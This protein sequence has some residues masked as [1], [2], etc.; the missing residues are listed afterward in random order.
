M[1]RGS[2]DLLGDPSPPPPSALD[3]LPHG[4]ILVACAVAATA[5]FAAFP[6]YLEPL[7]ETLLGLAAR[8][9]QDQAR[10]PSLAVAAGDALSRIASPRARAAPLSRGGRPALAC[11]RAYGSQ[12]KWAGDREEL[13]VTTCARLAPPRRRQKPS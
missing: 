4:E 13:R 2:I 7:H 5:S 8:A 10:R 6:A 12:L 9:A 1:G 3:W 11:V